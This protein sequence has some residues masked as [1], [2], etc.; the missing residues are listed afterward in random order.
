[1]ENRK[2]YFGERDEE[3]NCIEVNKSGKQTPNL[4][5]LT[6]EYLVAC[7]KSPSNRKLLYI[8]DTYS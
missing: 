5:Q 4:Y 8:K 7:E 6:A 1:M 3:G 2:R